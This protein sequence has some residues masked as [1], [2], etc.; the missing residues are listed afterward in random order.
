MWLAGRYAKEVCDF[1]LPSNSDQNY[2]KIVAFHCVEREIWSDR[3]VGQNNPFTVDGR[4][5][6]V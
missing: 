4:R 6:W 1:I 3:I 2:I 5:R